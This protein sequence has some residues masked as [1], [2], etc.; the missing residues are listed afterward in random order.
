MARSS[1]PFHHPEGNHFPTEKRLLH[2]L[3]EAG[4]GIEDW[5]GT[6]EMAP[7]P[8]EWQSRVEKVDAELSDRHG[9]KDAWRLAQ[10]QSTLIGQLLTDAMVTGELLTVRRR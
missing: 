1:T 7:P 6:E 5:R 2:L 9:T 8:P 4:L 10:R 3:D